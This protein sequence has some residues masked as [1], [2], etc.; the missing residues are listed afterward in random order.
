MS[1]VYQSI[2][3]KN[4]NRIVP[5]LSLSVSVFVLVITL[6]GGGDKKDNKQVVT[7]SEMLC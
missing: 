2:F 5:L 1:K 7:I 4:R 6:S 3:L